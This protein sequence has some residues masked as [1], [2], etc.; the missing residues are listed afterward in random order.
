MLSG[1]G[2]PVRTQILGLLEDAGVQCVVGEKLR[3]AGGLAV[4]ARFDVDAVV[5]CVLGDGDVE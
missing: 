1:C 3:A 5:G 2:A 4:R